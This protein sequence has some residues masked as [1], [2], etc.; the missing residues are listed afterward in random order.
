CD[1]FCRASLYLSRMSMV[2]SGRP[3]RPQPHPSAVAS[4]R[5]R[6]LTRSADETTHGSTRA[7]PLYAPDDWAQPLA[8]K[9]VARPWPHPDRDDHI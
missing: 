5:R 6:A 3:P 4:G 7:P 9:K 1:A 8:A 2:Y